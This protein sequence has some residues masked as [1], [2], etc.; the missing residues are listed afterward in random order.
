MPGAQECVCGNCG[1]RLPGFQQAVG[2]LL[3][4]PGPQSLRLRGTDLE[5]LAPGRQRLLVSWGCV[6]AQPPRP[7]PV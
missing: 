5:C 3:L 2:P 7:F 6:G 4:L 1:I